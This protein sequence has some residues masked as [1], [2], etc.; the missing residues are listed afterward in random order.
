MNSSDGYI[1]LTAN[2]AGNTRRALLVAVFCTGREMNRLTLNTLLPSFPSTLWYRL[3]LTGSVAR[4]LSISAYVTWLYFQNRKRRQKVS[5]LG[6]SE[7]ESA[8]IWRRLEEQGL[9]DTE[10][11]H[12]RYHY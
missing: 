4:I 5:T 12:F 6:L 7:K 10:T 9:S 3:I 8:Q 2:I 11:I 1:L